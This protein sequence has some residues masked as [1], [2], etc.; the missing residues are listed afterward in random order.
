MD[1]FR[2]KTE[3]LHRIDDARYS[4]AGQLRIDRKREYFFASPLR[5]R[6]VSFLITKVP[7]SRLE[8]SWNRVV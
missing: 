8:M 6:Q 7:V 5:L 2:L 1:C 3:L 4:F